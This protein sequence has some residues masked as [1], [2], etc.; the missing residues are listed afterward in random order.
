MRARDTLHIH[1]ECTHT[2]S[3]F[4]P[5]RLTDSEHPHR[6]AQTLAYTGDA[7]LVRCGIIILLQHTQ[8]AVVS[9]CVCMCVSECV[10]VACVALFYIIIKSDEHSGGEGGWFGG[11]GAAALFNLINM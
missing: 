9:L 11:C 8:R 5:P 10:F 6:T 7:V 2:V 4:A 1:H 3:I